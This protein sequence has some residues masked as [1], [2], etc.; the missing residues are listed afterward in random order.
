MRNI[1][2]TVSVLILFFSISLMAQKRMKGPDQDKIKA[3]KIA[4]I[5][6]QLNLSSAEAEK[7]WPI[8][9]AHED[10]LSELRKKEGQSIRKLIKN[11]DEIDQISE[12]DA[13]EVVT[14]VMNIQAVMLEENQDYF[15]KL[16]K[17]LPYKKIL[18]LQVAERE[19]KRKLFERLKKR[20]K[21]GKE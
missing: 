17:I 1:K 13:K 10:K 20:R 7:F 21:R 15:K 18:K 9:N 8:Y 2:Y 4:Y 11:K 6:D 12:A 16:K 3:Y 19:F 5:T 14:S